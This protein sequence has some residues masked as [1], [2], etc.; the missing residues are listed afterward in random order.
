MD[1]SEKEYE[2]LRM[3]EKSDVK[4]EKLLSAGGFFV[5]LESGCVSRDP[6]EGGF[7]QC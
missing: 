7:V 6:F 5:P 3:F 4:L 1:G 2:N